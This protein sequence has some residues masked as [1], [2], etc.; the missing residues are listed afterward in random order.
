M[1]NEKIV[2]IDQLIIP[3]SQMTITEAVRNK[4][5]EEDK[6][7]HWKEDVKSTLKVA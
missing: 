3:A 2:E 6:K 5:H 1:L 4:N 7:G